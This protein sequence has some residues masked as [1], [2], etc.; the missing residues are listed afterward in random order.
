MDPMDLMGLMFGAMMPYAVAAFTMKSVG[1][2]ANGLVKVCM[3]Q[4]PKIVGDEKAVPDS[5]PAS[6]SPRRPRSER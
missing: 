3:R 2:T 6:A 1:V 4:F 5:T